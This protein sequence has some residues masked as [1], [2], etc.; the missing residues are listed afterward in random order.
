MAKN[1]ELIS[2][3]ER[4][5][6]LNK[7]NKQLVSGLNSAHEGLHYWKDRALI[8]EDSLKYSLKTTDDIFNA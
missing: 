5:R 3:R 2:L 6:G 1:R 8:L 4:V 7:R